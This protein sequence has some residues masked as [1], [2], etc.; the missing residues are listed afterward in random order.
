MGP[1][2]PSL[3][4]LG[5]VRSRL[6][7]AIARGGR[8]P[9]RTAARRIRSLEILTAACLAEAAAAA[10]AAGGGVGR[11][12]GQGGGEAVRGAWARPDGD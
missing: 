1:A 9:G 7:D 12:S 10:E 4:C 8:R 3:V 5:V 2:G 11:A 6:A